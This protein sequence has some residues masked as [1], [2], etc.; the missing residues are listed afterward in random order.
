M[1]PALPTVAEVYGRTGS[2]SSCWH[3]GHFMPGLQ[4]AGPV[5]CHKRRPTVAGRRGVV[6]GLG[7]A[8]RKDL[9]SGGRFGE[10]LV[11]T[12]GDRWVENPRGYGVNRSPLNY[13]VAGAGFEPATFGL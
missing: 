11:A 3:R 10:A 7:R 1:P 6:N 2:G 13:L 8:G 5:C 9:S 4:R 12:K